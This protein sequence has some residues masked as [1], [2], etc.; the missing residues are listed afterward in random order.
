MLQVTRWIGDHQERCRI[1]VG[2]SEFLEG[3][4]IE[5]HWSKA[6][7]AGVTQTCCH[8]IAAVVEDRHPKIAVIRNSEPIAICAS[9]RIKSFHACFC[10]TLLTFNF[11]APRLVGC[12]LQEIWAIPEELRRE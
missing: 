9:H 12:G 11:R 3:A 1:T 2:P 10:S 5:R 7:H 6:F 4:R 8:R